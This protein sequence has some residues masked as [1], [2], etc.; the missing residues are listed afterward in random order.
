MKSTIRL[1]LWTLALAYTCFAFPSNAQ[2]CAVQT[3]S[4][5]RSY[6]PSTTALLRAPDNEVRVGDYPKKRKSLIQHYT[7]LVD[8]KPLLT[9][10]ATAGIVAA[11]SDLF[12]Q[13]MLVAAHK[14]EFIS[15]H[16]TMAFLVVGTFFTGPY[17]HIWYAQLDKLAPKQSHTTRTFCKMLVDQTVGVTMFFPL[18]FMAYELSEALVMGRG[19]C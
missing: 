13:V 18:F 4:K 19:T 8:V 16:R 12:A 17:L 6:T 3:R 10:A 9:K 14:N 2:Q 15:W 7:H 11:L 1:A 5:R